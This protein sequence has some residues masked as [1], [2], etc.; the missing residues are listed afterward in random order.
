MDGYGEQAF[1]D[2]LIDGIWLPVSFGEGREK[3][4]FM[5]DTPKGRVRLCD[6][7]NRQD[8]SNCPQLKT[9]V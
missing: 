6:Y 4:F 2:V 5:V 3:D 9:M 1:E 8:F 7:T